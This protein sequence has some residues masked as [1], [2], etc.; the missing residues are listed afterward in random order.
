M[1][2]SDLFHATAQ[3]A[4]VDIPALNDVTI[5]PGDGV[6]KIP[7]GVYGPLPKETVGLLLGRSS[8][9]TKGLQI[10]PGVIDADYEGEILVTMSATGIIH[11]KG[12]EKM[13]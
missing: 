12:G 3:S 5:S 11:I 6:Q 7:T 10:H 13:A 9:T 4:A 1:K 2:V 8:L